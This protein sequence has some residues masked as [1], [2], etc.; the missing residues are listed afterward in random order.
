[1]IGTCMTWILWIIGSLIVVSVIAAVY[2]R[3]VYGSYEP[4]WSNDDS[5]QPAE[6]DGSQAGMQKAQPDGSE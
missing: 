4:Y 6:R 5:E 2:V 1:M 3:F